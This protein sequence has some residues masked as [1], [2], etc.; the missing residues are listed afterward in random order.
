MEQQWVKVD[1]TVLPKQL[2]LDDLTDKQKKLIGEF[3]E[4]NK[5]QIKPYE[6]FTSN[7]SQ[8]QEHSRFGR[9]DLADCS[10][11]GFEDCKPN[12]PGLHE[13]AC[14][15]RMSLISTFLGI[16]QFNVTGS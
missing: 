5:S 7:N 4:L 1:E 16:M 15:C 3:K 13:V 14:F 9:S 6:F 2:R 11:L 12:V 10:K 8:T